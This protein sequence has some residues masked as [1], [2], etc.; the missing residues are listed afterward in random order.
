MR[1]PPSL[2]LP[3]GKSFRLHPI[4]RHFVL[5]ALILIQM[6]K[7]TNIPHGSAQPGR[8]IHLFSFVSSKL[9][10]KTLPSSIR[11]VFA[12]NPPDV[13]ADCPRFPPLDPTITCPFPGWCA[14][15]LRMVM[16]SAGLRVEEVVAKNAVGSLDWGTRQKDGRWTGVLGYLANGTAD[17][18]CLF[19]QRTDLREEFFDLSYL[20]TNVRLICK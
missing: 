5:F 3:I 15:I 9:R 8:S 18:A 19:Y 11:V 13:F 12:R 2:L 1:F 4:T 16:A 20:V 6:E 10:L 14:E 17:T 7:K